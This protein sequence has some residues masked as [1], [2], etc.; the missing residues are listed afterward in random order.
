MLGSGVGQ[1]RLLLSVL[2]TLPSFLFASPLSQQQANILERAAGPRPEIQ[3]YERQDQFVTD[4][5]AWQ[6]RKNQLQQRLENGENISPPPPPSQDDWHHVTGPEDLD[7]AIRNAEGYQQP[8]YQEARRF[9]RT[10]HLSFPLSPL[11]KDQLAE[12]ALSAHALPEPRPDED[13]PEVILEENT[14][15]QREMA[16]S[17]AGPALPSLERQQ[18]VSHSEL[19]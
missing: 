9:D 14:R 12:K 13:I 7:T 8:R 19:R 11:E 16:A 10:T 2:L 3:H 6:T 18:F 4:L 5:L 17:H 15:L 1:A